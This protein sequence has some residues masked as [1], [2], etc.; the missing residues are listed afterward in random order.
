MGAR[1]GRRLYY[2]KDGRFRRAAV[3]TGELRD[4]WVTALAVEG[5]DVF[6]GTYSGGVTRL[7]VGTGRLAA[8]HLGGGYVNPGGLTV[9]GG[10]LL[11]ATMDGLIVRPKDDDGAAWRPR[12][13][14]SP[15]RDVTAV[16][17]VGDAL[18]V[19]SRRGIGV[20]R[21]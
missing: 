11:A 6:V 19:A 18:W 3:A 16:R 20:S 17:K 9:L 2:G 15:G 12:P 1:R 8:S 21:P 13:G 14:V 4:D 7:R 10:E 5:S